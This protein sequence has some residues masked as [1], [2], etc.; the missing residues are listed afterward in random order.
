MT[1]KEKPLW[2]PKS[3]ILFVR[4]NCNLITRIVK[5]VYLDKYDT[6]EIKSA[7]P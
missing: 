6:L 4:F 2:L 7:S 3:E 5:Y 1:V